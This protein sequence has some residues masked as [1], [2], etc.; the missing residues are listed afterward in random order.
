MGNNE[1][2]TPLQYYRRERVSIHNYIN[3]N[4]PKDK[5]YHYTDYDG[6]K[7]I[8]EKKR[9]R[10]TDY[11]YL[12]D[13]TELKYSHKI[14]KDKLLN[15]K[16]NREIIHYV[17][18]F[19]DETDYLANIYLCCFSL[20][21]EKLALWRYYANNGS[22]FAIT[23]NSKFLS[24]QK[25]ATYVDSPVFANV[26]YEKS[27]V[28]EIVESFI[29]ICTDA[30]RQPAAQHERDTIIKEL[31]FELIV[32]FFSISPFIKDDSFKDE[33]EARLVRIEGELIHDPNTGKPFFFDDKFREYIPMLPNK[34]IPFV[35]QMKGNKPVII[36]DEF[37]VS[38]ISE[39]WV[40]P[41][42]EF[43][44]ASVWIRK[45]LSDNGFDLRDIEIKQ[46]LFPYRI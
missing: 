33:R 14:I 15:S 11:R 38:D 43:I 13:P 31:T 8:I 26:I 30:L 37:G 20:T 21:I 2:E 1:T 17:S 36:P 16:L 32:D 19:F 7:G 10:Y 12:N 24:E 9:L 4:L 3:K 28:D 39:I 6:L 45:L 42:C 46:A 22:G 35:H 25:V 34:A 44:E 23:F 27:N 29:N 5:I 18:R 41:C 40:G